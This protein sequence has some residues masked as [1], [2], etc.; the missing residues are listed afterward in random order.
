MADSEA[1]RRTRVLMLVDSLYDGTGGAERFAVGLASALP[2]DRYE[3][4]MC[5]TR[6]AE[7]S[8]VEAL[9]AAGVSHFAL[10]RRGRFD[11]FRFGRLVRFLRRQ[12][13]DVLHCHKFGSNVW[14]TLIGRAARVPVVIA[15]E[16]TWSYEGQPLRRLL[17]GR[18]VGRLAD[19]FVAVSSED[20]R[21]MIEV[22][23]VSPERAITIPT[24]YVPRPTDPDGDLRG[25]L[26]LAADAPVVG[27]VAQLRPQ[28][29][30]DVLIKAFARLPLDLAAARLVI[31][32]DGPSRAGLELAA[33]DLGVA[34][35]VHFLGTRTDLTTILGGIDV[36][37][38]SSDFEGLPLFAFECMAHR[39]P[40]VATSV[41]G[42]P[43][44]IDAR[45]GV[46]VP[47]R[48]PDALA[49]ALAKLLRD[50]AL[51]ESIA[52][53][54]EQRLRGYGMTA[55]AARF[56]ELYDTLLAERGVSAR[57]PSTTTRA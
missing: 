47:R 22:E 55:I 49:D 50:P 54:A 32:G 26:G 34:D 24:G 56:A 5:T 11:V 2:Q 48:D 36:A 37:A 57:A 21:R 18:L 17:D 28:K 19:R 27:T 30:L 29:A 39:T 33:A 10:G 52:D 43:D 8:L 42:L 20:R 13:V 45:S 53:A 23:G 7:G 46:L 3:L 14:G 38:M 9:D 41:G 40:L 12:R 16:H 4:F 15:H 1:A 51:R 31:A 6:S 44:L 25:E 35:R